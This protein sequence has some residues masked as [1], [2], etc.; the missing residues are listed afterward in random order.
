[1]NFLHRGAL[2]FDTLVY[3]TNVGDIRFLKFYQQYFLMGRL[4]KAINSICRTVSCISEPSE[5]SL[6]FNHRVSNTVHNYENILEYFFLAPLIRTSTESVS[7]LMRSMRNMLTMDRWALS[8]S[9]SSYIFMTN[10]HL[11]K[12]K[13]NVLP[14]VCG[15]E[16]YSNWQTNKNKNNVLL[17]VCGDDCYLHGTGTRGHRNKNQVSKSFF[18]YVSF[19]L[20]ICVSFF[21]RSQKT[22]TNKLKTAIKIRRAKVFLLGVI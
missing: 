13:N 21:S 6:G 11:S 7:A 17:Q 10:F 4:A 2:T 16:C 14:Q 15:D 8:N 22:T 5:F 9:L 3:D 20:R 12:N 18:S 1:M 19:N